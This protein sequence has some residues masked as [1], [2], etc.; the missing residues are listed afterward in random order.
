MYV[1]ADERD[2]IKLRT[3]Y[4][5]DMVYLYPVK[6]SPEKSQELLTKI[7]FHTNHLQSKPEFYNTLTNTCTTNIVDRVNEV[8]P[9]RIPWL[10]LSVLF[11]ALSDQFAYRLGLLD[12]SRE[13]VRSAEQSV[14]ST[15]AT[16]EQI[17]EKLR[18]EFYIN[19][20]AVEHA[21]STEFSMKIRRK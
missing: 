3:N 10:K 12:I 5:K 8:T 19:D 6:T 11:P 1:I 4:R 14:E 21:T 2:V 16:P 18:A 15:N 20:L 7:L 17:F 13:S 9:G